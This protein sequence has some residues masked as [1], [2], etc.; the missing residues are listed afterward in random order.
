[1]SLRYLFDE[2]VDVALVTALRR[3]DP[4]LTAW[5]IGDPGA[6]RRGT[7]PVGNVV[8]GALRAD[9]S[10]PPR[11]AARRSTFLA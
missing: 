8:M 11:G 1:M 5:S 7:P 2:N 6:P 3:R 9:E 4:N 10:R